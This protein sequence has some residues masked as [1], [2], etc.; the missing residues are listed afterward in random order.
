VNVVALHRFPVKA[1]AAQVCD[2][3]EL[4]TRGVV[5]DRAYAVFGADGKMATGKHS[6]R[7][8][9]MD[10]VFELAA[11]LE[12]GRTYVVLPSGEG[13]I[14]GSPDGDLAL[15]E[16][17]GEP[18]E[19]RLE[20]DVPH[21]DAGSVS[22]VGTATLVELGR[23]EGDGRPVDARHLRANIVVATDA[24]YVEDD[25]VGHE[26]EVGGTRLKVT[27]QIERCRMVGVAQV[28]LPERPAMLKAVSDHHGLMAAVYADVLRPGTIRVGDPVHPA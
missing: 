17:F 5:G 4:D 1:M 18:V 11:V 3:L 27:E 28:G 25:W 23:H 2:E 13:V 15:T 24:P 10:P 16:H 21:F 22:L 14:A 9:R 19:V 26:L 7:F 12:G 8:R 20:A 6:R